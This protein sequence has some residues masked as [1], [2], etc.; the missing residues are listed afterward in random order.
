MA[1][2]QTTGLTFADAFNK[3][4][5]GSKITRKEWDRNTFL[6]YTQVQVT[7]P[8]DGK[9]DSQIFIVVKVVNQTIGLWDQSRKDILMNDWQVL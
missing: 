4:K 9:F 3:M 7:P 8:S 2:A 5:D 6:Y 1:D